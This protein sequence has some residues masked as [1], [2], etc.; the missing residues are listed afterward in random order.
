MPFDKDIKAISLTVLSQTRSQVTSGYLYEEMPLEPTGFC[1][2]WPEEDH[3][4]DGHFSLGVLPRRT[5]L[6]VHWKLGS[7]LLLVH[8]LRTRQEGHR[9]GVHWNPFDL[10]SADLH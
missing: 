6:P 7:L 9:A 10:R 4:Q 5:N 8:S 2:C 3:V 1:E